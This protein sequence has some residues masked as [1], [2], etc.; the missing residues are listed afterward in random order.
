MGGSVSFCLRFI[1]YQEV[2]DKEIQGPKKT[3]F[4][5]GLQD[6]FQLHKNL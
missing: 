4:Q 1:C 3:K 5:R 6:F 2:Q